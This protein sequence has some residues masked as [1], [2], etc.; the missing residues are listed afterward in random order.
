MVRSRTQ[1]A[2]PMGAFSAGVSK[3]SINRFL[4]DWIKFATAQFGRQTRS[5]IELFQTG[6]VLANER[7]NHVSVYAKIVADTGNR[8]KNGKVRPPLRFI[9]EDKLRFKCFLVARRKS[10]QTCVWQLCL[11]FAA[12]FWKKYIY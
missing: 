12:E 4:S 8:W 11:K 7:G 1:L 2:L 9:D 10:N 3:I 6:E 5:V